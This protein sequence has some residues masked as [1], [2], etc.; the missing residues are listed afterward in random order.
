MT[1]ERH[2]TR[3]EQRIMH[4]A[5]RRSVEIVGKGAPQEDEASSPL[6]LWTVGRPYIDDWLEVRAPDQREAIAAWMWAKHGWDWCIECPHRLGVDD[7]C[8]CFPGLG[9]TRQE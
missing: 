6:P 8:Q 2:L 7:V 4:D 5:L 3:E 9:V 1:A